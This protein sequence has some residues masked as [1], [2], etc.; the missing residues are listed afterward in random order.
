[1]QNI[2]N[3]YMDKYMDKY[4]LILIEPGCKQHWKSFKES[5]TLI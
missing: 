4:N 3:K 5:N 2:F 1:M